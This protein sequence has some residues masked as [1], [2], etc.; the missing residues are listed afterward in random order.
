MGGCG[1]GIEKGGGCAKRD[2]KRMG[3][4]VTVRK[5]W[6]EQEKIGNEEGLPAVKKEQG[7]SHSVRP[8]Q[9]GQ[10][11]LNQKEEKERKIV[12]KTLR[13]SEN[14]GKKKKNKKGN[15]VAKSRRKSSQT[16]KR[17]FFT[18]SE[19]KANGGGTESRKITSG[20]NN[21]T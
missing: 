1:G 2:A 6:D 5:K 7:G 14:W 19:K 10:R 20:I 13:H 8:S 18:S 3:G 11:S 17:L 9:R 16:F 15:R 12:S 4:K 21:T